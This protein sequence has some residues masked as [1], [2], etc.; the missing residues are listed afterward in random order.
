MTD[1]QPTA[2]ELRDMIGGVYFIAAWYE[3]DGAEL[4]PPLAHGRYVLVDGQ[5]VSSLFKVNSDGSKTVQAL[6]GRYEMEDGTFIYGYDYGTLTT[7]RPDGATEMTEV[8]AGPLMQFVA[9]REAGAI[10]LW[11]DDRNF[12]FHVAPGVMEFFDGH[13]LRRIW[14]RVTA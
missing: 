9:T 3:D 11:N 5:V 12:G 8:G 1:L 4:L 6:Y 2:T 13:R 10:R 7:T 14:R